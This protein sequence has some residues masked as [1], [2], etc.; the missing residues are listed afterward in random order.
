[1]TQTTA[2]AKPVTVKS[3]LAREDY[4][5][6]FREILD[7][8]APQFTASIIAVAGLLPADTDPD[9]IIR[10]ALIAATL[11][12]PI[13]KDL[14]FAWIIPY[15]GKAQFQMGYKGFIQLGMRTGQYQTMNV[16]EVY[17]GEYQ[18]GSRL[19]GEFSLG[20]RTSETIVGFAAFF[21]MLNGFQKAEYWTV[22]QVKAHAGRYSQAYRKGKQDSPWITHF[23]EMGCKT[24]IKSLLAQW[25]YLS[26]EMQAAIRHD[27]GAVGDGGPDYVD[28]PPPPIQGPNFGAMKKAEPAPVKEKPLAPAEPDRVPFAPVETEKETPAVEPATEPPPTAPS[29]WEVLA[30]LVTDAHGYSWDEFKL[31]LLK[32]LFITEK[33][34][35]KLDGFAGMSNALS[36]RCL[37]AKVG[38]LA[39][40]KAQREN[41]KTSP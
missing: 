35:E 5:A 30:A 7:R 25:G 18:P 36:V 12:L 15:A 28:N 38:L 8:R 13:Q 41:T 27:Q 19:A 10:S 20:E 14:G 11:D 4:Q 23:N 26:V 6:R 29:A 31:V 2:I 9:S 39:E 1:M 34:A 37:K 3:L 21:R 16:T 24:V 40:L 32:V 17:E 22:E 33:Q